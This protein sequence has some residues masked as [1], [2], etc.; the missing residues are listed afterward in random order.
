MFYGLQ[1]KETKQ[2][3]KDSIKTFIAL[4][5]TMVPSGADGLTVSLPLYPVHD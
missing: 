3:L 5:P 4:G 2:F 1:E